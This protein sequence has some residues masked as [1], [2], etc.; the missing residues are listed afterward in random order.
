MQGPSEPTPSCTVLTSMKTYDPQ[1]GPQSAAG[2][3]TASTS[4][5]TCSSAPAS[6]SSFLASPAARSAT[7]SL[8]SQLTTPSSCAS[9]AVAASVP[10]AI[11]KSTCTLTSRR[12]A[13]PPTSTSDNV[14]TRSHQFQL[15]R[16]GCSSSSASHPLQSGQPAPAS[17]VFN[18][19]ANNTNSADEVDNSAVPVHLETPDDLVSHGT[20]MAHTDTD[21]HD[22]P[23]PTMWSFRR[24][25]FLLQPHARPFVLEVF[26]GSGR[27]T[28]N[29]RSRGFDAWGV[30]W[31]G[32][33]LTPES[34]AVLQ[35]DLTTASDQRAFR[36][37]LDHP[38]LAAVHF[39]PPCGTASRAREIHLGGASGHGPP[40]LRDEDHPL[41]LPDLHLRHPHE[42]PRVAAANALYNFV[43]DRAAELTEKNIIWSIENPRSSLMWWVPAIRR[44]TDRLNTSFVYFQ[45]CYYGGKRPKWTGWLH[46]PAGTYDVLYAECPGIS[47]THIH[48]NWGMARSG[49]FATAL[50]TVYPENLCSK[51]ADILCTKLSLH[52]QRPLPVIRARGGSDLKR[53]RLERPAAARLARGARAQ[54]LLPEFAS[55][56]QIRLN[57]AASDPRCRPGYSWKAQTVD[58]QQI[59]AGSRTVRTYFAGASGATGLA[60]PLS[61]SSSSSPWPPLPS[62]SRPPSSPTPPILPTRGCLRHIPVLLADDVYIGR[63][64]RSRNGRYLAAS[65]WANQFKVAD[66]KDAN[67]AVNRFAA[68]LGTSPALLADLHELSGKRV[69]CHCS[70]SSPCH[71]DALIAAFADHLLDTPV[72]DA[73]IVLGIFHDPLEFTDAALRLRHP[74]EAHMGSDAIVAGLRFRMTSS[75]QAVIDRRRAALA[76]WT[77]RARALADAEQHLHASLNPV[78]EKIT[79]NKKF[80]V[81]REMLLS[82]DFPSTYELVHHLSAGFPL[83]GDFPKTQVFPERLRPALFEVA[84]LWKAAH[85]IRATV[86]ASCSSSGDPE[87]DLRLFDATVAEV[88]LGWLEGPFTEKDLDPLGIWIPSRRFA[89]VQG[90]KLRPVDDYSISRINS[91]LSTFEAISPDDIDCIA[92]NCR[93]HADALLLPPDRRHPDSPFHGLVRHPDLADD[94]LV[95]RLWDIASAYKHLA[96]RPSQEAFAVIAVWNPHIGAVEYF[97]QRALPFGATAAVLAFNWVATA[98]CA[99]LTAVFFIGATNYYDDFTVLERAELAASAADTVEE[100]FRLLGWDLK[101]LPDFSATPAPLGAVFDLSS[102]GDGDI[103]IGNKPERAEEMSKAILEFVASDMQDHKLLE[104]IRGR[105]LFARSL[106]FGRFAGCALRALNRACGTLA[107]RSGQPDFDAGELRQALLT[108]ADAVAFSPARLVR[109]VYHAPVCVFTDGAIEPEGL[110]VHASIGGVIVDRA[111]GIFWYFSF[112]VSEDLLAELMVNSSNPIGAVE[113][114]GVLA[115]ITLWADLLNGR[116]MILFVDNDAAKSSLIKGYSPEI[117]MATLTQAICQL[118]IERHILAYWERVPSASNVAD[119]PS[120]GLEPLASPSLPPPRR[121]FAPLAS[122]SRG[123]EGHLPLALLRQP[124]RDGTSHFSRAERLLSRGVRDAS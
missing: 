45:H 67:D 11:A 64:H 19:D 120:R 42:V 49:K 54:P 72:T 57:L 61:P 68:F 51:V 39:A 35:M 44:L 117:Q 70:P 87:L 4:S 21:F 23:A 110:H 90:Q 65:K 43:G 26:C 41:G 96:V 28:K 77:D 122:V 93:L 81:F 29:L 33:K 83:V 118:E 52:P 102:A 53:A 25:G 30:D 3:S 84:D 36:H 111:S 10:G 7:A 91:T 97:K 85:Q 59:P 8:P 104:K 82:I 112:D 46:Y 79:A 60:P 24:Q 13:S 100:F 9:P 37:L 119:R 92:A 55:Y 103:R 71:G 123:R 109:V 75:T 6:T 27:L 114:L 108:L 106:C 2:A 5:Q 69:V 105:I 121:T 1:S 15:V 73:T 48:E 47:T 107:A 62:A 98:L 31:K 99:L 12:P 17:A 80:L 86:T 101:D 76:Y 40:P 50:E 66:C 89:V 38:L 14:L 115:A 113:L 16:T 74:F 63:E 88:S 32:G 56:I 58:G 124:R 116:S 34:P 20:L 18:V 94:R 95:G 78:V 22:P